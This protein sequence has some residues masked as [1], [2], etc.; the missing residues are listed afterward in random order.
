MSDDPGLSVARA[1]ARLFATPDGRLLL[2]H[3][4]RTLLDRALG[5]EASDA[6]LRHREGQRALLLTLE[7]LAARGRAAGAEG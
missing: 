7:S 3:L 5:P 2:E 1:C 4:R 6:L